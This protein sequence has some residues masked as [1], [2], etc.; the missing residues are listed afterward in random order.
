[1]NKE[2]IFQILS[3]VMGTKP[4]ELLA[5][6]QDRNLSDLGL[7]SIKFIQFIV[8]IEEQFQIE[9]YDSDLLVFNFATLESVFSTLEKYFQSAPQEAVLKKVFVCDCDNVL[10]HGVS[11]EEKIYMDEGTYQLQ[12]TLQSLYEKGVLLCICSKNEKETIDSAFK[13]LDLSLSLDDFV[14]AKINYRD[15][16]TNIKE[17]SQEL[18]LSLDSFVFLDDSAYELGLVSS[19]LPQVSVIQANY[20]DLSFIQS[21]ND[22]FAQS[23]NSIDRTRQ[24]KEQKAREKEKARFATVEEYNRSLESK[25]VFSPATTESASRIAELTQR[26]NQFNL[27]GKRY[28]EEEILSLINEGENRIFVLSV[29]DKYGDMGIVGAAIWEE[30][31]Q[32][33][34]LHAFYLSC[35]AFGRGFETFI[36][37][38]I[39]KTGKTI[40][41]V[42]KETDKNKRHKFFYRDNG[43]LAYE[44]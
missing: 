15:K 36:L 43:V 35:R 5:F 14:I 40:Y 11:G 13:S 6:P 17:I 9:V 10:W 30:K 26:T 8:A 16:A 3:Q 32:E 2:L 7:D 41:G 20:N 24:Y 18:N 28:T 37:D 29:S 42:Y 12:K 44:L 39:K 21:I 23:T 38:E 27:S 25:A 31:E 22:F 19:L 34:I 1:M 4:E 33:I